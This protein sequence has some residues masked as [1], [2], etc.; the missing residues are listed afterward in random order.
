M[1]NELLRSR[2][3]FGALERVLEAISGAKVDAYD[4]LFLKDVN[5]KPY[6]GWVEADG[7][8]IIIREEEKVIPVDALPSVGESGK[9]YIFNNEGYFWD[10]EKFISLS[11]PTDLTTLESELAKLKTF[12]EQIEA[13]LEEID[14]DLEEFKSD[15]DAFKCSYEKIKYEITSVPVGTLIDYREDEIRIMCPKDTVFTKQSVGTGGNPNS[16]YMTFKTYYPSKDVVGYIEHL[17][18]MVDPEIL[19]KSSTDEYGRVYQ[20]TWLALA[21]YNEASDMWVYRGVNSTKDCYYGYDYQIDWYDANGLMIGSDSI[22]IN[23]ANEECYFTSKPYYV[24]NI[25][26]EVDTKIEEKIAEL[27]A[28]YKIIEF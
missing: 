24:G 14:S 7:T 1:A 10:G 20:T 4:I 13:K 16:Y 25:M 18:D 3:A 11:K 28:A 27:E 6:I 22:R 5:G 26:K 23:L 2:H 15:I 9:I 8:P 17:G 21:D 12:D 19:I